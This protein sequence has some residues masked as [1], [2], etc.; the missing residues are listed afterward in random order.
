[1]D[2]FTTDCGFPYT[3]ESKIY[4]RLWLTMMKEALRELH[5]MADQAEIQSGFSESEDHIYFEYL[6]FNAKV[7]NYLT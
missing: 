1:M 6:S 7:E 5:Y 2:I 4:T 3:L